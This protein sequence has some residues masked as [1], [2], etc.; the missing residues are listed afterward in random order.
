M[1]S[2][3]YRL[4][5]FHCHSPGLKSATNSWV[6]T[7]RA[8]AMENSASHGILVLIERPQEKPAKAF[9]RPFVWDKIDIEKF[10]LRGVSGRL[11]TMRQAGQ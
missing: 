4:I 5:S 7:S 9:Q 11:F 2:N 3:E 8:Q 1:G 6:S 10:L